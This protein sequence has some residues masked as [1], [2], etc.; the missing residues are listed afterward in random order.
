M[1]QRRIA[2]VLAVVLLLAIGASAAIK[3][4][5]IRITVVDSE[6]RS[7]TIDDSGV[8]KNCDAVNFDAYCHNSKTVQVTNT[9]LVQEGI[10]RPFRIACN[11]DT[12]WSRC[13]PL[14]RG[15]SFDARLEKHGI[16]VYFADDNGK[17]RKQLY[18]FV[19]AEQAASLHA[20]AMTV[21]GT[22]AAPDVQS[23]EGGGQAALSLAGSQS[24]ASVKCSFTSTP[25]GAEVTVDARYVGSTPSVLSLGVGNHAVEV[26][27]PGFATWKRDLSVSTGSN[28]T[29][30][31]VLLKAQ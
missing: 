29:V 24:A 26:S 13:M 25:S 27:M 15:E 2:A 10:Q 18:T 23:A 30:N 8:P 17:L 21:A 9:L 14:R 16:L 11:V 6:T 20:A 1:N 4:S 28:L 12:K 5:H 19:A 3:D 22:S 31:A 7:V